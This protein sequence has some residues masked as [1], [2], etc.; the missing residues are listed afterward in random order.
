MTL[1]I[2]SLQCLF[3]SLLSGCLEDSIA[4]NNTNFWED[5]NQDWANKDNFQDMVNIEV[6]A[7]QTLS[8]F[9]YAS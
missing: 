5:M 7:T 6:P 1:P 4:A 3:V 9:V 8:G 2:F